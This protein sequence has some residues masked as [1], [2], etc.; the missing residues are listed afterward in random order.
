MGYRYHPHYHFRC[1]HLHHRNR[2]PQLHLHN[3]NRPH[4]TIRTRNHH[5]HTHTLRDDIPMPFNQQGHTSSLIS[6]P[7]SNGTEMLKLWESQTTFRCLRRSGIAPT[8]ASK[9]FL[10]PF[11]FSLF[12]LPGRGNMRSGLTRPPAQPACQNNFDD[13]DFT[14]SGFMCFDSTLCVAYMYYVCV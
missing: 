14:R 10:P 7:K 13:F 4:H 8:R 5:T 3:P 11:F 1:L 2:R 12:P 9:S 6:E